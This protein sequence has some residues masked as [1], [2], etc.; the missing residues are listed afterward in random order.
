MGYRL[1][2]GKTARAERRLFRCFPEIAFACFRLALF[3]CVGVVHI[4]LDPESGRLHL[5]APAHL[6]PNLL[7]H[8]AAGIAGTL[9]LGEAVL[10]HFRRDALR[11]NIQYIA[12]LPL[13]GMGLYRYLLRCGIFCP[14]GVGLRLICHERQL[15]HQPLFKTL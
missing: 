10:H 5:Q 12:T 11:H 14:I 9:F 8:G 13:A 2:G 4:L 15:V 6:F 1:R 7:H 3:T